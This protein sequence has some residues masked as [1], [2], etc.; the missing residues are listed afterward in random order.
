MFS[1]NFFPFRLSIQVG[2]YK[3]RAKIFLVSL[4]NVACKSLCDV[5][6]PNLEMFSS[7]QDWWD[8]RC[9]LFDSWMDL[10]KYHFC[11]G[12]YPK[13]STHGQLTASFLVSNKL[14]DAALSLQD[15]VKT[16]YKSKKWRGVEEIT[17]WYSSMLLI[18]VSRTASNNSGSSILRPVDL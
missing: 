17:G 6:S 15:S 18:I 1:K 16:V 8:R 11:R 13:S 12:L 14:K 10:R 5:P 2:I 4:E 3:F 9:W 7:F